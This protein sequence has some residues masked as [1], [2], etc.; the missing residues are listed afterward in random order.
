MHSLIMRMIMM[1]AKVEMI[2]MA[3]MAMIKMMVVSNPVTRV[4]DMVWR[5]LNLIL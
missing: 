5:R 2:M 1:M 3:A 4:S